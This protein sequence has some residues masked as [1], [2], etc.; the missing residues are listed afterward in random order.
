MASC[1][2]P[3]EYDR[4]F[5]AAFAHRL[6]KRYRRKGLDPTA[7]RIVDALTDRGVDGATVLEIG[8]GIGDIQIELLRQGA[9]HSVN[10]ELSSA[11]ESDAAELLRAAGLTE[12]ADRRVGDIAVTP[13][14]V[15]SADVVVMH[16]VVCCY[17]NYALLL[18][19]AADHARRLLVFS[20]PP[21]NV[22]ARLL[23]GL[24]NLIRQIRRRQFRSFVHDPS[25]MLAVLREHG[26]HTSVL[27]H[28]AW[29]VALA[30][31]EPA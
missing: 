6:A 12:R 9:A 11:Y 4:A 25:H 24:E 20:Y 27:H 26:L 28:G 15:D 31:W 13:D 19:V 29:Q 5:N 2:D 1:C 16:R 8:G 3:L 30:E 22:V 7:R 23:V 10:V 21:G 14:V 18:T 17:P